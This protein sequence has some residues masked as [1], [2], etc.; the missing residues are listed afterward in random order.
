MLS[1]LLGTV[2]AAGIAHLIVGAVAVHRFARR[3][4]KHTTAWPP[5]TM[6]K[7]LYGAEP[8]LY[9]AL[10]SF[11]VQDYPAY[12]VVFGVRHTHDPALETVARLRAELPH[13]DI[14]V[15]IDATLH[16]ANRKVSNLIN[17]ER[18][19]RH[20]LYVISD[21]DMH[22]NSD[23]LRRVVAEFDHP[24]T[25]LVT[26]LYTGQ[27]V[28]ETVITDFAVSNINHLFMP[29]ALVGMLCGRSDCFGATMAL[30]RD[31]LQKLGGWTVISDQLADDFVLGREVKALG[32]GVRLATVLPATTVAEP[33]WNTL[34]SHEMRWARTIRTMAPIGSI[35]GLIQYPVAFGLMACAGFRLVPALPRTAGC[36]MFGTHCRRIG[37][38]PTFT[39]D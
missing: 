20:E 34:L 24:N 5:V 30:S 15:V 21:S 13:V 17:M 36:C 25:G 18:A 7:P 39:I 33:D 38:R 3:N 29:S 16:G 27:P 19:A 10:R 1:L 12:Q 28:F 4:P 6:L 26:S 2:C 8:L 22:V 11:C 23:Y 9:E 37:D 32:L 14:E 35:A 31:T